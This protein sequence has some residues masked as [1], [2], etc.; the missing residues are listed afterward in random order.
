MPTPE[1]IL[2][3][4]A[5]AANK[6]MFLSI[7]WHIAVILFLAFLIAGKRPSNKAVA[8]GLIA[9]LLSV[10][11][12]AMMVYNPFNAIMFLLA[13]V[14]FIFITW[15]LPKA[16]IL[17]KLDFISIIGLAMIAFGFVYPHFLE[18]AGFL[19]Y[20]YSSPLGLIPCPTLSM[21]IGF[22]LL[23]HGFHSK[24]WMLSLALIGIFYGIFGVFRLKVYLDIVLIAGALFLL[25]YAFTRKNST[26]SAI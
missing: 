15:K 6:F 8:I 23:F 12:V 22:T 3:G 21:I 26:V 19:N 11:F 10:A 18:N 4:L 24:K 16:D 14:L 13:T 7:F 5:L 9:L 25:V 17:V 1:E 20:L 2:N